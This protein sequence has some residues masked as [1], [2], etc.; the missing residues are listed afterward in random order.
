KKYI[1][2]SIIVAHNLSISKKIDGFIN[3]P[4]DK[5]VFNKNIGVTEFLSRLNR[6]LGK[7]VMMIYSEKFAVVPLTTHI[8]VKK[9]SQSI[10]QKKILAKIRTLNFAY[11]E[12]F[13][14]QP[15]IKILGLNPHNGEMRKN[16]EELKI[17]FPAVNKL[18][19]ERVKITGPFSVDEIFLKSLKDKEVVVGMYHDQVLAPFKALNKFNAINITLGLKYLR[20]S[21]DH[22]TGAKIVFKN[23]GNPKSLLKAINC[24]NKF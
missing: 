19:N 18:K 12:I 23:Q 16:S 9:I 17:I 15:V 22:G 20:I 3:C 24:F 4:I 5:K 13:K 7:E 8:D 14:K 11:K 21:P 1:L 6:S 2:N 10:N